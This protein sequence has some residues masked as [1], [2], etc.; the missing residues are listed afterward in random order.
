M[1]VVACYSMQCHMFICTGTVHKYTP[2]M[3]FSAID[4][5]EQISRWEL[6]LSVGTLGDR[7]LL[8]R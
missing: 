8:M 7:N 3:P 2:W 1:M 5:K 4:V 6:G